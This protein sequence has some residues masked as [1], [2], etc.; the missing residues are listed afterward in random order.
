MEYVF[1]KMNILSILGLI[2]KQAILS[3]IKKRKDVYRKYNF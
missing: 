2:G 1:Q 3:R